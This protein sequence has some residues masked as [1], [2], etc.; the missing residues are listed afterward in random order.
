MCQPFPCLRQPLP[1]LAA[2]PSALGG[3]RP[4]EQ[5]PKALPVLVLLDGLSPVLAPCP[6]GKPSCSPPVPHWKVVSGLSRVTCLQ[7]ARAWLPPH[8]VAS[9]GWCSAALPWHSRGTGAAGHVSMWPFV[10][11]GKE[12]Q[13][14]NGHCGIVGNVGEDVRGLLSRTCSSSSLSPWFEP[15]VLQPR[16]Y[17]QGSCL[18]LSVQLAL[19]SAPPFP[20]QQ[21]QET[22][23]AETCSALSPARS[24]L[25]PVLFELLQKHQAEGLKEASYQLHLKHHR[26]VILHH[27][28]L[29]SADIRILL[30]ATNARDQTGACVL[31]ESNTT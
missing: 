20:A 23:S 19:P 7:C 10:A 22:S 6:N 18:A 17:S 5:H 13:H 27:H 11:A 31:Q 4:L 28:P 3:C 21:I 2:A 14:R 25:S 30:W 29:P 15:Q 8:C 16:S 26:K 24:L 12:W 1:S 9:G